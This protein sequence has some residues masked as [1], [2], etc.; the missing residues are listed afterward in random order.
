[1]FITR[2]K[3]KCVVLFGLVAVLPLG[4][5]AEIRSRVFSDVR[6]VAETDDYVGTEIVLR[7]E[8]KGTRVTGQWDLYQGFD[9]LTIP[10][11]GTV[12][13]SRVTMKGG[14]GLAPRT[15]SGLVGK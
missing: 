3:K 11:E 6:H 14:F 4:L 5:S 7:L 12:V 15:N 8:P 10:L 1:M 2:L 9:P 13:G